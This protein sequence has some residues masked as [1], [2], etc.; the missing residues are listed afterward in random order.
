M[1]FTLYSL[2]K[3]YVRQTIKQEGGL[4]GKSAYEIAV[5]NGFTGTE[6]EWLLSL[7]GETPYIGEN[8]NWFVGT[9]DTGVQAAPNLENY[10]SKED[11]IALTTKEILEICK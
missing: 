5:D 9:L 1:D 10:Y 3:T 6:K 7:R 2:M 11:L 4:G 8:G